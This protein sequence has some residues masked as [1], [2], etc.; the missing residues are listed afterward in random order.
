MSEKRLIPLRLLAGTLT[1]EVPPEETEDVLAA[2][3]RWYGKYW[4]AHVTDDT[5]QLWG[6]AYGC[7][8]EEA[9]ERLSPDD[10]VEH[11]GTRDADVTYKLVVSP[12]GRMQQ[13][14][15]MF[16]NEFVP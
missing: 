8:R 7:T 16:P 12:P 5:G 9:R 15:R 13:I 2:L 11:L 10:L 3:A 1:V 14:G 4:T 6:W